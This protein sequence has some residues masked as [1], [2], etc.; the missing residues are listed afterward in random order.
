MKKRTP[1]NATA[2]MFTAGDPLPQAATGRACFDNGLVLESNSFAPL[3]PEPT[4]LSLRGPG[5]LL[6]ARRRRSRITA[7]RTTGSPA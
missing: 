7:L 1:L 4:D 5:G 6:V 3:V 2:C